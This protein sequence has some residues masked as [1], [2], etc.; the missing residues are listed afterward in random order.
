MDARCS[1]ERVHLQ[2]RIVGQGGQASAFD[3]GTGFEA[4]VFV[5]G[6]AVF[7]NFGADSDL[8]RQQ[9][10]KRQPLQQL[11]PL[12]PFARVMGG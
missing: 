7:F 4:G 2:S 5:V 10:L 9:E 1:V 12:Q 8:F 11:Q 6:C 3:Q